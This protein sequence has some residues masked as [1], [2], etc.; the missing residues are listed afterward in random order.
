MRGELCP[1]YREFTGVD[2][3]SGIS[4]PHAASAVHGVRLA[5]LEAR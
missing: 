2:N 1:K 3:N 5:S 4:V